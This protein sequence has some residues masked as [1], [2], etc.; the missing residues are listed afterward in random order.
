MNLEE[1][2]SKQVESLSLRAIH[3]GTYRALFQFS[4]AICIY[5]PNNT[6]YK[7]PFTIS[8][9]EVTKQGFGKLRVVRRGNL[10]T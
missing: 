7:H 1:L 2:S 5:L 10:D 4:K 6:K 8:T 9:S 3:K